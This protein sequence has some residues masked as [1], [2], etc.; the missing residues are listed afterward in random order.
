MTDHRKQL[1]AL[2][3]RLG[4]EFKTPLLLEQALTHR[5]HGAKHNERLEFLGDAVLNCAVAR[6]L[7]DKYPDLDEGDLSRIRANLVRQQALHEIAQRLELGQFLQLGEGEKKSGGVRRP[8]I[9]ADAVEALTGA[10]FIDAGFDAAMDMVVRFYKPLIDA[11]DPNTLGKD[12]K[13]LL[14]EYL[15]G[16]HISL[17]IYSVIAT[18]GAAHNQELEVECAVPK[19]DIRVNGS[20]GSRRAAEQIAAKRALE[21]LTAN[22][23][24]P[25]SSP[26]K[27]TKKSVTP[28]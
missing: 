2:Q 15:Q 24:M 6:V 13:T 27:K 17:P 19:L 4:V 10:L 22:L 8:S 3:A 20:A 26:P 9:L 18:R 21:M 5:S 14:Q 11:V 28:R 23:P 25:T 7:Y 16:Q 12:A 1:S